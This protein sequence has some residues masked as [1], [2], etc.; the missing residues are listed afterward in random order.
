MKKR[1]NVDGTSIL[2]INGADWL[3]NKKDVDHELSKII[4]LIMNR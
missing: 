3:K 4:N 1:N 2:H